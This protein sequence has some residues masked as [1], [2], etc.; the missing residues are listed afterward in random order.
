ML[1]DE[2]IARVR[3]L[4]REDERL[5][6]ALLYGSFAKGEGDRFSD[7]EFWLFF[8]EPVPE[9]E[10]W[11]A[12]I[13]PLAGAFRNEFGTDV[14]VFANGIR[15]EF[16]F[17]P[18]ERI[19]EVRRWLGLEVPAYEPV[20]DRGGEL[21]AAL[22]ELRRR[23]VAEPSA[24]RVQALSDGLANWLLVGE[25]A[26]ARGE[27]ARALDALGHVHRYLLWL[28]RVAEGKTRNHW[29]TPARAAET[30]LSP[31]AYARFRA[32][33]AGLDARSL[34]A[35]YDASRSWGLELGRALAASYGTDSRETL[36]LRHNERLQEETE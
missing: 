29:A 4:C 7:I 30:D 18:A 33:V 23:Y 13:A 6:A 10:P 1:Q 26:L 19:A 3:A 14:V 34:G 5:D 2:L 28:A 11:L 8:R 16:H 32:C 12:R 27:L 36:L 31:E 25:P 21:A 17:A 15:G 24:A 22:G 9:P 35:A 20:V